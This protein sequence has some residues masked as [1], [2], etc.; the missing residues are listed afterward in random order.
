L[1]EGFPLPDISD[2]VGKLILQN[3]APSTYQYG[4]HFWGDDDHIFTPVI[5][6]SVR[7]HLVTDHG[8]Y[9]VYLPAYD[10]QRLVKRLASF[11]NTKWEVFSK[12]NSKKI[13]HKNISIQPIDSTLFTASMASSSGVLCGAG[14][15]TPAEAL[16][17]GKKLLVVPMKNQYEQQLNAETLRAMGVPV[18]KNLKEK[19][20]DIISKWIEGDKHISVSY[21][22]RTQ[23]IVDRIVANHAMRTAIALQ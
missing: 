3:Y 4:F 7:E 15:E 8:H 10:D 20:K 14:F 2:K 21:E 11:P 22:D 5:R 1:N 6:R 19:H 16:F 23:Q 18:I 9:T 12:H 17:L 13:V